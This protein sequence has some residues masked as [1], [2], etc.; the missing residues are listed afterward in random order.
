M[1]H[2]ASQNASAWR[3]G[4]SCFGRWLRWDCCSCLISSARQVFFIL[5]SKREGTFPV[6][7]VDVL[8]NGSIVM[9]LSLGMTLVIATGGVDLSVGAVMAIALPPWRRQSLISRQTIL[10]WQFWRRDRGVTCGW[11]VERTA[12]W[13]GFGIQPIVATL[14][15]MV[16]GRAGAAHHR[17]PDYH[18]S[19]RTANFPVQRPFS[20]GRF[21]CGSWR[22]C[23]C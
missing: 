19:R 16:A 7:L 22:S 12:R 11:R 23:C 5:N 21:Q 8:K 18:V 15:L 13:L 4:G 10:L 6:S 17:W 3:A 14:I 1:P 9:L 2:G 20:R